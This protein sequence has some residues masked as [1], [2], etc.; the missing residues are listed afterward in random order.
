VSARTSVLA[1]HVF[2]VSAQVRR[3]GSMPTRAR[4]TRYH[5]RT[6]SVRI[7]ACWDPRPC[8]CTDASFIVGANS[9]NPSGGK[10]ASTG[11]NT[12]VRGHA[13]NGRGCPNGNFYRRTSVLTS[14]PPLILA[15]PLPTMQ[16]PL[17]T[18]HTPSPAVSALH[19]SIRTPFLPFL[20]DEAS[21]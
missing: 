12:D 14:L 17:S 7:R 21:T 11:I 13:N 8:R 4:G 16:D 5:V 10:N 3:R 18:I 19:L 2:C 9:K 6:T 20:S 1:T 15:C